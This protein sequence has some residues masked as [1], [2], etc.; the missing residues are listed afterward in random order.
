[1]ENAAHRPRSIYRLTSLIT[2]A[3][4]MLIG[5]AIRP[6]NPLIGA[7]RSGDAQAIARLLA[8]GADANQRWGVNGWTPLM[9]AIHKNQQASVEALLSGGADV[10][11][12]GNQGITAL[13]MAAGYG[14][15]D[16]VQL[17]LDKGADPYAET[18]AGDNALVM[19]VG[20][21]P[22]IDKFTIGKCQAQT[23]AVLLKK[24]PDLKLKD[25]LHGRAAR[26]AA[27]TG[28]CTDVLSLIEH[29]K[30]AGQSNPGHV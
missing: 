12:R 25:N 24:A 1:M 2:L 23:V 13:M 18:S 17:L 5:C 19:A 26:L 8:H 11:A 9:H 30:P 14:Y 28:G 16:I 6:D 3:A 27:R 29:P 10:N 22:D 20:G 7:A 4:S 15:A 21:V